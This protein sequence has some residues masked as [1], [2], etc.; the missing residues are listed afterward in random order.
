MQCVF[1]STRLDSTRLVVFGLIRLG[2]AGLGWAALESRSIRFDSLLLLLLLTG[3]K[4]ISLE[5]QQTTKEKKKKK[6]RRH[7]QTRQGGEGGQGRT[8]VG[9]M[10]G[11]RNRLKEASSSRPCEA[12]QCSSAARDVDHD[13]I[14]NSVCVCVC[15]LFCVR[16]CVFLIVHARMAVFYMC[17]VYRH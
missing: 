5:D 13:F 1:L 14:S 11:Q 9:D 7:A 12:L 10:R 4:Q 17:R 6:K 8:P 16:C 15:V 2:W 3:V